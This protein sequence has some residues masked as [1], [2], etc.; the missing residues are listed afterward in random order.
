MRVAGRSKGEGI[1][2]TPPPSRRGLRIVL[3]VPSYY[4]ESRG[5]A[6]RQARLQATAFTELG[7]E[8]TLMA[9]ALTSSQP[10]QDTAERFAVVRIPLRDFPARGGRY[11]ISTLSWTVRVAAWLARRRADYDLIYVFHGRLHVLGPLIGARLAAR[12]IVVKPGGGGANSDLIALRRKKGF[13]GHLVAFALLD[14]TTAFV[15]VSGEI[16]GDLEVDGVAD[17]RIIRIPNGVAPPPEAAV[18]AAL[19]GRTGRRLVFPTRLVED[20]GVEVL[21][22]A[23][24]A[25]KDR[26]CRL[27]LI[28]DGPDRRR[29]EAMAEALGIADRVMFAGPCEDVYP[30]LLEHDIFLSASTREGQSNALLEAIACGLIPIV[31]PASG[32]GDIVEDG[33]TGYVVNPPDQAGF[34]RAID[35]VLALSA[36]ARGVLGVRVHRKARETFEIETV[37]RRLLSALETVARRP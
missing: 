1:A 28:G 23:L 9:P 18:E 19:R 31:A 16:A 20:K 27:T 34:A 2:N 26:D 22:Q 15:A 11:L 12:P 10:L 35:A 32:V 29:F 14:W 24:A 30:M 7:A 21:L 5:G 25:V 4:P 3:V 17:G 8:V 33:V 6:E 13:Y 37:A 36:E